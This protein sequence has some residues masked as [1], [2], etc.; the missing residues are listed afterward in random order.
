[1]NGRLPH[2]YIPTLMNGRLPLP[3]PLPLPLLTLM[4]E[5]LP[6][7]LPTPTLMNE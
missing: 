5:R 3:L 6:L 4:N 1:M 7:P 2:H